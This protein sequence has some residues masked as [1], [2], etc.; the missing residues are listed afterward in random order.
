RSRAAIVSPSTPPAPRFLRTPCHAPHRA[1][2]LQIRSNSARQRRSR[3]RLAARHSVRWSSSTLHSG[4]LELALMPSRLPPR[5]RVTKV[6][7]LPSRQLS[8]PS[9]V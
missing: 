1:T 8:C 3:L 7:A 9:P 2:P 5:E 4:W 6:G